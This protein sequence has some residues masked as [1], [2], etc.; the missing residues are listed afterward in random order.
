MLLKL[1]NREN[2][3]NQIRITYLIRKIVSLKHKIIRNNTHLKYSVSALVYK[4]FER[5]IQL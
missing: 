1:I 4:I 2:T 3:L 5:A